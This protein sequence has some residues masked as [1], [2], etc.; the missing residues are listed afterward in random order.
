MNLTEISKASEGGST[1]TAIESQ[2]GKYKDA[3]ADNT[4]TGS[5]LP[6]QSLPQ[7]ADPNPFT[8][9]PLTTGQR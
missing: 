5:K 4:N 2:T 6:Q 1:Q 8:L 3:V 7:A 9:G